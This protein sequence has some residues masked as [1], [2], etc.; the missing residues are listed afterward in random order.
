MLF[1]HC[2]LAQSTAYMEAS[3]A[4]IST[5]D[6]L[7]DIMCEPETFELAPY[8]WLALSADDALVSAWPAHTLTGRLRL[9]PAM[10]NE[11]AATPGQA[12]GSS[13]S[14]KILETEN[15]LSE[16]NQTDK[17]ANSCVHFT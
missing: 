15:C 4:L 3:T 9:N 7:L 13:S 10:L 8:T 5:G 12:V 1:I 17:Q 16:Y 6:E 11:L 2:L 14:R